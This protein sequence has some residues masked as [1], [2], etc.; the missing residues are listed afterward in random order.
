MGEKQPQESQNLSE[1]SL[2]YNVVLIIGFIIKIALLVLGYPDHDDNSG[3]L[4]FTDI[5]YFVFTDA[6]KYVLEGGSPYDRITYRYTPLMAYVVLPN[7]LL[8]PMF[9][10]VLFVVL[11]LFCILLIRKIIQSQ[12]KKDF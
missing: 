3:Q 6:A 9:G 10:K 7:H 12:Y 5:D 2:K 11:E 4:K 1:W 8:H